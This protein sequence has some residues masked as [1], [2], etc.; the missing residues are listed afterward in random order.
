MESA[1]VFVK[2]SKYKELAGILAKIQ[3]KLDSAN[4]TIEQLQKIKDEEDARIQEWKENLELVQSKL[5]NVGGAL[6]QHS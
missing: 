1:P 6:H 5:E 4:K 3:Q 2:I